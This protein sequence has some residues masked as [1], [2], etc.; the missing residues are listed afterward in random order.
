M[1]KLINIHH[2]QEENPWLSG[3]LMILGGLNDLNL[4][5]VNLIC[6]NLTAFPPVITNHGTDQIFC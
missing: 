1:L 2:D 3:L 6:G 4:L 5:M